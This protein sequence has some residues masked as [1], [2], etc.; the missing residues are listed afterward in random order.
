MALA[1]RLARSNHHLILIARNKESANIVTKQLNSSKIE[2]MFCDLSIQKNIHQLCK[3]IKLRLPKL[4]VLINC[5]GFISSNRILT[6]DGVEQQLA[7][8]HISSYIISESLKDNLAQSTN[9]KII[10]ISSRAVYRG[11]IFWNNLMLS[12]NYSLSKA[13]NQSKLL[14]LL[15]TCAQAQK[16]EKI[17]YYSFYPGLVNTEIGLKNTHGLEY[18]LGK[19]LKQFGTSPKTVAE[20]L[21]L[22]CEEDSINYP[23]GSL[24]NKKGI[25]KLPNIAKNITMVEKAFLTTNL[26]IRNEPK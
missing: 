17:K 15:C 4:D 18:F 5:A 12:D 8:N 21:A 11:K 23:S 7:V 3:E 22:L 20:K 26:L 13:Y 14:N 6:E 24:L 9:P 2:W 25:A 16:N 19:L 10:N 1:E